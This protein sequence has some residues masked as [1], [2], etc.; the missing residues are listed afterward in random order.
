MHGWY[1]GILLFTIWIAFGVKNYM[2]SELHNLKLAFG[3]NQ[4][5]PE[6]AAAVWGARLIWPN[7]LL[8]DRQDIARHKDQASDEALERLT[9]WLNSKAIDQMREKLRNPWDVGLWPDN[10]KEAVIYEDEVGKIVGNCLG[11]HGYVYVVAYLK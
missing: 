9:T 3:Y 10:D 5:I 8:W 2:N 7:D 11:S 6:D 4:G 1:L